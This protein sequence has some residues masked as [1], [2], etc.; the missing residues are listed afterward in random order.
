MEITPVVQI[1]AFAIFSLIAVAGALGMATT[2]SM[3][4]SG[5]FLMASFIGVAGL[6]ILL[7]ADLLALLQVMMYIGGMLVMILFMVLFSHDPG[8]AM[9]TS[10]MELPLIEKFFSFG[11]AH[12]EKKNG[13]EMKHDKH[14]S[15]EQNGDEDQD[16]HAEH[17][18]K[19]EKSQNNRAAH[20]EHK[21]HEQKHGEHKPKDDKQDTENKHG[22]HGK[23]GDKQNE[24]SGSEMHGEHGGMDMAGM[25][26]TTPIKKQAAILAV[27]VGL[28][29]CGLILLRPAWKVTTALPDQNSA[30]RVGEMLM[31]K[32][33]IA[34]EGA[35]LLILLGIFGSVMVSRPT[36]HPDS[37]KREKIKAAVDEK[38]APVETDPLEPLHKID[39]PTEE[40]RYEQKKKEQEKKSE[41]DDKKNGKAGGDK[42][43]NEEKSKMSEKTEAEK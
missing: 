4:R 26:M 20:A 19:N 37:S 2:M 25:T 1:F 41:K 21:S 5:I 22:E 16:S 8:G 13:G 10:M 12:G 24:M 29:L 31:E 23:S 30:E 32:Y 33:M 34:F 7:L 28:F 17:E 42:N 36:A 18:D 11:L 6:F 40:E 39:L 3:F 14:K 27:I 15:K 43:E 38:P 9:M 35:G